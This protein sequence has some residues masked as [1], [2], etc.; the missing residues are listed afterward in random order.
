MSPD[1]T[2]L[3]GM[4]PVLPAAGGRTELES[5]AVVIGSGF[6]G[7]V[8]AERLASHGVEVLVLERGR[9]ISPGGFPRTAGQLAAELRGE[10]NPLGALDYRLG[11]DLDTLTTSV[12]GGGSQFYAGVTLPPDDAVFATTDPT[13]RRIWPE[14]VRPT[15][16]GEHYT[17]I[18]A[19]LGVEPWLDASDVAA[20]GPATPA[21]LLAGS[22]VAADAHC[23]ARAT[24]R[25]FAGRTPAQ[26]PPLAKAE[27]LRAW[28]RGH[29][30]SVYRP[31]LALN[32]TATADGAPNQHGVTRRRCTLCGDCVT[33]CNVGAKNTLTTNYLPAAVRAG[34]QLATGVQ[35]LA[36]QPGTRR[37]W[38]LLARQHLPGLP[39]VAARRLR[40][41]ADTVVCAAGTLG[42]TQLLLA[43]AAAGLPLP[44]ALGTRISGNGD[45]WLVAYAGD[46]ERNPAEQPGPTITLTAETG[47]GTGRSLLQDGGFPAPLRGLADLGLALSSWRAA[48]PGGVA[49]S[50]VWL[51]IGG[52][53]AAGT[54]RLD[55]HGRLRLHWPGAA[56]QPQLAG[57]ARAMAELADR[58]G[59]QPVRGPRGGA[60]HPLR[61]AVT[62][63][64]LGGCPMGDDPATSVVDAAGRVYHPGGGV[65]PGLYVLDGS[66]CPT[67]LAVNPSLGIAALAERAMTEILRADLGLLVQDAGTPVRWIA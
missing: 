15:E 25:D 4:L 23:P 16:L 64:P 63:H 50:Q 47:Q 49:R 21:A 35:V 57:R 3:P 56:D 58:V 9:Q 22:P 27:Q 30:A 55:R 5:A 60:P 17:R 26:R 8:A 40:I 42:S 66:V 65:H 39:A 2:D 36:V 6:G 28:G 43:S 11:A 46:A 38:L 14:R 37:R 45:D 29:G 20:G 1:R 7:A 62:V 13:G 18:R 51:A 44:A 33:G 41:H 10:D 59:A 32:L 24:G 52:D 31:P 54:A 53:Q 34:A 67:P 48:G 19:M 61:A 12:L